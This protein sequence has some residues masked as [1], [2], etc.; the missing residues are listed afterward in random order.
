MPYWNKAHNVYTLETCLPDEKNGHLN[1]SHAF[2]AFKKQ[3]L[4]VRY[5]QKTMSMLIVPTFEIKV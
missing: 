3:L 1:E 5:T 2:S 4:L